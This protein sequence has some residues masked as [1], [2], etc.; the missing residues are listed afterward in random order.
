MMLISPSPM[1]G[2]MRRGFIMTK[3][4]TALTLLAGLLAFGCGSD[5]DGLNGVVLQPTTTA[6]ATVTTGTSGTST[7]SSTNS[8][9]NT[10]TATTTT[11]TSTSVN[12]GPA[13]VG[14]NNG[15]TGL[16]RLNSNLP[17]VTSAVN[18]DLRD[19]TG[20][21]ASVGS[22]IGLD[23]RPVNGQVYGVS[24]DA[25]AN[26]LTTYLIDPDTGVGT[27]V[28]PAVSINAAVADLLAAT[29]DV[30][31]DPV[32]D[33]LHVTTPNG[34]GSGVGDGTGTIDIQVD[35]NTGALLGGSPTQ[36]SLGF[37]ISTIRNLLGSG[38]GTQLVSIDAAS[39][40]LN[41]NLSVGGGAPTPSTLPITGIPG[42]IQTVLGLDVLPGTN[43]NSSA[44][45]QALAALKVDG[46]VSL[47][48]INLSTGAAVNLGA[49]P[50]TVSLQ[51]LAFLQPAANAPLVALDANTGN[52]L[53]I[54][55]SAL[56][57][58]V[59]NVAVTGLAGADTLTALAYR[60]T[61]GVL[62]ALGVD[63]SNGSG[64][65]YRVN[66][67]SGALVTVGLPLTG[68][69][70]AT[71]TG[72]DL[73]FDPGT[74]LL[75][76]VDSGGA[77]LTVNVDDPL[78]PQVTAN[79]TIGNA[80]AGASAAAFT[81]SY[82]QALN[83]ARR[84]LYVIDSAT[85]QLL[86]LTNVNNPSNG[87]LTGGLALT[88]NGSPLDVTAVNSLV[89]PASVRVTADNLAVPVGTA[90]AL[91]QV[92][93]A[94]PQLYTINLATGAATL[95]GTPANALLSLAAYLRI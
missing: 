56:G 87:V 80:P 1:S 55:L 50:N 52:L 27:Q 10:T 90:Y 51:N 89:I 37:L 26:L 11:S 20:A 72:Y 21:A 71:G 29:A 18:L 25:D 40:L 6:T 68:L 17:G 30:D 92:G 45:D 24:V 81:N 9:S 65:I 59:A 34:A 28:G 75:R 95:V 5:R 84:T 2:L 36:S 91:L 31:V 70:T 61:T 77:L 12:T 57:Q 15:G 60:P 78:V 69:N 3:H 49:L 4:L 33:T 93:S 38:G 82:N 63:S 73:A 62:Y 85:D 64:H 58:N 48:S 67:Q 13:V 86:R 74:N 79:L 94:A 7:T 23:T 8:N 53:R 41:L 32:T 76:I 16:V 22:L 35:L 42:T 88:L 19:L 46:T 66:P 43:P 83:T 44:D 39:K 54:S 14:L 47:F